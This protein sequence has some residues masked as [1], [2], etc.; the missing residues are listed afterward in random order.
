[1]R[2]YLVYRIM[3]LGRSG[4]NSKHYRLFHSKAHSIDQRVHNFLIGVL[5]RRNKRRSTI[6]ILVVEIKSGSCISSVMQS[7]HPRGERSLTWFNGSEQAV[8]V[9]YRSISPG[10]TRFIDLYYYG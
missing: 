9:A 3:N 2:L 7:V 8:N 4:V 1:M 6:H 5:H 10:G